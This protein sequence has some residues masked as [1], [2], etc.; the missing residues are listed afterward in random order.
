MVV[1]QY[2]AFVKASGYAEGV[3]FVVDSAGVDHPG[4]GEWSKGHD[5]RGIPH[6]IVNH[7][8]PVE[9]FNRVG[10]PFLQQLYAVGRC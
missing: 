3:S 5:K 4:L 7:F 8:V 1:D 10:P 2:V 6:R 9:N